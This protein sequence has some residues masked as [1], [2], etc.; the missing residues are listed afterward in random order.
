M[1]P[2]TVGGLDVP[3]HARRAGYRRHARGGGGCRTANAS[4]FSRK[5]RGPRTAASSRCARESWAV[6]RANVPI[7]PAVIEGAFEAW[8]RGSAP[9]IGEISVLYGSAIR[10]E[11]HR[12]CRARSWSSGCSRNCRGCKRNSGNAKPAPESGQYRLDRIVRN[13]GPGR[14]GPGNAPGRPAPETAIAFRTRARIQ[15]PRD[16]KGRSPLPR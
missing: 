3:G 2:V 11:E 13:M 12:G 8:P 6:Q 5:A 4:W 14:S 7:V 10:P 15:W 1:F 16:R 9:R